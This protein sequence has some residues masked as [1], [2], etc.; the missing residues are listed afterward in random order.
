[1]NRSTSG[2]RVLLTLRPFIKRAN[3]RAC[4]AYCCCVVFE[5][6]QLGNEQNI[7]VVMVYICIP[8]MI[9]SFCGT[10]L[11]QREFNIGV[12]GTRSVGKHRKCDFFES[13]PR[14]GRR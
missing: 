13:V 9:Q 1:M 3:A 14:A 10:W 6:R 5:S 2:L 7:S 12:K 11:T 4:E 8:T